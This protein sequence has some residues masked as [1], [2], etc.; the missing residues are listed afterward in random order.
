MTFLRR[1]W[2]SV[3]FRAGLVAA[4]VVGVLAA[5]GL[6][7]LLALIF[8]AIFA[9]T[10]TAQDAEMNRAAS[11]LE[12][13]IDPADIDISLSLSDDQGQDT[14]WA[15]LL[16]EQV[17]STG[18][19]DVAD[20][21]NEPFASESLAISLDEEERPGE[22]QGIKRYDNQDWLYLERI[23]TVDATT[24]YTVVTASA[25]PFRLTAFIRSALPF[26]LPLLIILMGATG[27]LTSFF[28]RRSLRSVE[29]MRMEVE[30]ITQQSLDRRVPE[31][32]AGDGIDKLAM[33]MND[34]LGRLESS[35]MQ[36]SQFL[37][38]ASHELRSPVAGLLAQLDV[39]TAYPDRVD[40]SVLLPKLN[41]QARRLQLLVDDLLF[42]S[43][44]EAQVTHRP[45]PTTSRVNLDALIGAEIDHQRSVRADPEFTFTGTK[46]VF[47]TGQQRDLERVVQNL[48][49][50]AARHAASS[51]TLSVAVAGEMAVLTVADDGD[52]ISDADA[53]RI[54][55]RFVRLDEARDRDAGGSGL[56]LAIVHEI[57]RRHGGAISLV[58]QDRPG[59]TFQ[60][61][62]PLAP[63]P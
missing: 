13:G 18:G 47:V 56:G 20:L 7:L 10:V 49:N 31:T 26:V 12:L 52:G 36:Q 33:T 24:A 5:V 1:K 22:S 54:F 16:D 48:A 57:V 63:P 8:G 28:S 46:G 9:T 42:L 30:Q 4:L 62:L 60:V 21:I 55:E 15:V 34:M 17:V 43:R 29:R 19:L 25:G 11:Q 41:S 44:S 14:F 2:R 53:A 27:L 59:A 6:L 3:S 39:A 45:A 37:A 40:T 61:L 51:V 58:G 50:N 32:G 23:V 38:D 35:T